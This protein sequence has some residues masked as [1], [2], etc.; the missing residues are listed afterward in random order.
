MSVS[1]VTRRTQQPFVQHTRQEGKFSRWMPSLPGLPNINKVA[2]PLITIL[3]VSNLPIA[4]GGPL[5]YA[6]CCLGC[7][8][9]TGPAAITCLYWC[10]PL[11][12]LPGP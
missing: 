1:S 3:L 10:M 4:D 5:E 6:A 7:S 9:L 2:L 12:F 8:V 11:I